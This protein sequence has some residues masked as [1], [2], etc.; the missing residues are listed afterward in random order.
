MVAKFQEKQWV[1][2]YLRVYSILE[3]AYKSAVE[4]NGTFEQW[5][6]ATITTNEH[7][8]KL[9]T[10]AKPE[11]VYDVMIKPYVMVSNIKFQSKDY[12]NC[13]P[14]KSFHL[15]GSKETIALHAAKY[16]ALLPSGECV[17]IAWTTYAD[18]YVDLNGKK[19]PNTLGKDQF[20][21]S[22]DV[23]NPNRIK[24]GYTQV[25]WTDT[26]AFCDKNSAHGWIAGMSCGFWILRNHNMDYLHLPYEDIVKKWGGSGW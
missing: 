5:S 15:D 7:G 9:R 20:V 1:T 23:D 17:N 26:P 19:N 22:F 12:S 8:T 24:P 13:M 21:F 11:N 3:N 2:A 16:T 10:A 6:G 25:N 18:F 4:N 14:D